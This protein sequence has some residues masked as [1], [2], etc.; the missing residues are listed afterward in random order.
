VEEG[1]EFCCELAKA[2]VEGF[3]VDKGCY[4][5]WFY[6]HPPAYFDDI[7]YVR[8]MAGTLKKYF[9]SKGINAQV[10]AVGKMGKPEAAARVLEE[11]WADFVMLGRPLLAD[12]HWPNKVREGRIREITHCIGDQEACIQSFIMGGH[13]CCA[14]NPYT[15]FEDTKKL[16]PARRGKKVAVIGGGPAGCEAAKT[17]LLKRTRSSLVR[18]GSSPGRA[19]AADH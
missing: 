18:K 7:P 13:P 10:I 19:A 16:E 14:V 5:N 3:D 4:D 11:N 15:G 8:D 2:G 12:P 17:C 9:Q 6:P 1:L